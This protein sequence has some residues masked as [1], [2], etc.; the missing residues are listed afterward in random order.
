[1]LKFVIALGVENIFTHDMKREGRTASTVSAVCAD[2]QWFLV[3]SEQPFF[4]FYGTCKKLETVLCVIPRWLTLRRFP[5][6]SVDSHARA[7]SSPLRG[8]E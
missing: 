7:D 5:T 3:L 1:M 2:R 8:S 6:E 4:L